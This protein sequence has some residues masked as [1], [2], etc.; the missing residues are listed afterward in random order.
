MLALIVLNVSNFLLVTVVF[1][2]IF[3]NFFVQN[4]NNEKLEN[5]RKI[6]WFCTILF[7]TVVFSRIFLNFFF[8]WKQWKIG[9]NREIAV[10]LTYFVGDCCVVFSRTF[11]KF[12]FAMKI[13]DFFRFVKI[14]EIVSFKTYFFLRQ[15]WIFPSKLEHILE[16]FILK[17]TKSLNFHVKNLDF[18]PNWT[19]KTL[20]EKIDEFP[21]LKIRNSSIFLAFWN[22]L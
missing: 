3:L 7:V 11:C 6:G 17:S 12:F 19:D 15:I 16:Y 1:S 14:R 4:K 18:D 21:D 20:G 5:N 10:V 2:Q 9:K 8:Q 22:S 13:L